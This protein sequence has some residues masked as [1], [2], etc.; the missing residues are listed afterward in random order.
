[1]Y[2]FFADLFSACDEIRWRSCLH[3]LD[4]FVP[5]SCFELLSPSFSP[6]KFGFRVSLL[7]HKLRTVFGL[8]NLIVPLSVIELHIVEPGA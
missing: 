8:L 4:D 5:E 2:F 7:L 3:S 6:W 1:M